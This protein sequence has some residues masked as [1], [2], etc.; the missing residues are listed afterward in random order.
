MVCSYV[1]GFGIIV[2][3]TFV[4]TFEPWPIFVLKYYGQWIFEGKHIV[5]GI[6]FYKHIF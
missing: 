1:C 4:L 3:L 6:V 2:N 5:E